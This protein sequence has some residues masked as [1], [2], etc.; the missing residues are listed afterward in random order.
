MKVEKNSTHT[1]PDSGLNLT[2]IGMPRLEEMRTELFLGDIVCDVTIDKKRRLHMVVTDP[3]RFNS[4]FLK[5]GWEN[6]LGNMPGTQ[7]MTT[8][9]YEEFI[10]TIGET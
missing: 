9:E 4:A 3:D 2:T 1:E 5:P 6:I 10:Q 7:Y 8:Q